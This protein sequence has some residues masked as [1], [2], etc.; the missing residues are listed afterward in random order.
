MKKII[1]IILIIFMSFGL[2]GCSAPQTVKDNSEF[3]SF[4]EALPARMLP[5]DAPILTSLFLNPED[6]GFQPETPDYAIES[7]QEHL[8]SIQDY[9]LILAELE[10]FDYNSLS[11][12]Q[13]ITYDVVKYSLD[14]VIE[15]ENF[16]YYANSQLGSF[17]GIN[18]DLPYIFM[19]IPLV[20]K[21]DIE[22]MI[23]TLND[24]PRAFQ[25]YIDFEK[26]KI[27]E[28]MPDFIEFYQ[29]IYDQA[30]LVV[31][32]GDDYFLY[33]NLKQRITEVDGLTNEDIKSYQAQVTDALTNGFIV[34]YNLL[35]EQMP[36]L[37][38]S[39]ATKREDVA[40]Y[41]TELG[42]EYYNLL[43][44]S[45]VGIDLDAEETY[46]YLIE[47]ADI[48]LTEIF[49]EYGK[50]GNAHQVTKV[51][52]IEQHINFLYADT[53]ENFPEIELPEFVVREV[54]ESL[55]DSFSPAAYFIPP[56][57]GHQENLIL[58]NPANISDD[59]PMTIIHEGLP[60][61]MYQYNY[62]RQSDIPT[63]RQ[64]ISYTGYSEGWAKYVDHYQI[65]HSELIEY[66]PS[67]VSL[68]ESDFSYLLWAI[69]D[70]A[71]HTQGWTPEDVLDF[72]SEFYEIDQTTAN[73]YY[74]VVLENPTNMVQYYVTFYMLRD[75]KEEFKKNNPDDYTELLFHTKVLEVG[76]V[77]FPILKK[78]LDAYGN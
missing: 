33:E 34:A 8:D 52:N 39:A 25:S 5:N 14:E 12:D 16:Y 54:D 19:A 22:T 62:V 21:A 41:N 46:E 20:D 66:Y 23:A 75:L 40:L 67:Y 17:L 56:I 49:T 28:G 74:D 71:I 77:P 10:E 1:S 26:A 70:V 32:A 13:Q 43:L 64:I 37:E 78:H 44:K 15:S 4:V 9:R 65:T 18:S 27:E 6:Y 51:E 63:I 42:I 47:K 61:H 2:I 35:V 38:K 73:Y 72:M 57:D 68:L 76:S 29:A 45:N 11:Y 48:L 58:F 50:D 24:L 36:D 69:I 60:G 53:L 55:Q 31:L 3:T 30:S 7:Y 59:T